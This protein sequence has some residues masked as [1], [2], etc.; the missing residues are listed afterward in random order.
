MDQRGPV[1]LV[2]YREPGGSRAALVIDERTLRPLRAPTVYAL[3]WQAIADGVPLA[4]AASAA[5]G[6]ATVDYEAIVREG[7]LLAPLTHV[8]DA[9]CLVSGTG[10]THLGSAAARQRMHEVK[11][12]DLTDSMRMFRMGLEGGKPPAGV[13]GAQPEWFYKGDGSCV[14]APEQPVEIPA[15]AMDGGDEAEIAG[16]YLIAPDGSPRRLGFALGNEFSDHAMERVNYLWLAQSKIRACSFGP[17][18]LVGALPAVVAG[19]A[20]IVR[21]GREAWRGTFSSGEANMSHAIANLEHH[22]FKHALFRRPGDVHVH[23]FGA[24]ALSCSDGFATRAGDEF[25]ISVP[26]FG[27]PLRNRL[28]H[29][30]AEPVMVQTL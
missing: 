30:A 2:Q 24:A 19:Q 12:E 18:L 7:R 11:D 9:R 27:R 28:T 22:H 13:V 20:R 21:D 5:A 17:E 23:Y 8:D 4:E 25:E 29:Q 14:R 3:A 1:R 10:L 26:L 6:Q 15:F 16:L